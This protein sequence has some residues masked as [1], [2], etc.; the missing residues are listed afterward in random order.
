MC[1]PG[2]I[3]SR[4]TSAVRSPRGW[5]SPPSSWPPPSSSSASSPPSSPIRPTTSRLR[6]PKPSHAAP[7]RRDTGATGGRREERK[8]SRTS[9]SASPSSSSWS[10]PASSSPCGPTPPTW[11]APRPNRAARWPRATARRSTR[12]PRPPTSSSH[13][14]GPGT[15]TGAQVST[16]TLSG[17][18][19]QVTVTGRAQA[20]IP[21]FDLTVSATSDAPIQEYRPSG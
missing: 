15:L 5:S 10:S 6:D 12:A 13:T 1:R 18:V 2:P 8:G 20:L 21:W 7:S 11:P 16:T 3:S 17:G 9:S 4:P 19:A 14:T